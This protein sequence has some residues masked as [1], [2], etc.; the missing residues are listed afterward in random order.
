MLEAVRFLRQC[1]TRRLPFAV[2]TGGERDELADIIQRFLDELPGDV[3]TARLLAPTDSPHAF[4]ESALIQF[5]LEPFDSTADDL[6][7]LLMLVLGQRARE[8]GG[9]IL[10]IEDAQDFGPKVFGLLRD[11]G[12]NLP[13]EGAAPMILLAGSP[14]LHRVLDSRGMA[15]IADLTRCR[16]D[17]GHQQ[18]QSESRSPEIAA[19]EALPTLVLMLESKVLDRFPL[20]RSRTLI[21][22]SIYSDITIASRYV[23]RHH[24]L[25]I[26]ASKGFWLI[27]LKSTNGTLVNS[28]AI[29]QRY[30][31]HGDIISIGNHRLRYEDAAA[32]RAR[33]SGPEPGGH[34]TIVME[35]LRGVWPSGSG[36]G[37]TI[38]PPP[39]I[40][41]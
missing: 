23:S 13:R 15:G 9:V 24:A 12:R 27:D 33:D 34:E 10:L 19:P 2:L 38:R 5:G 26:P 40:G 32:R 6:Q 35:S 21:G 20:P 31:E 14:A 11:I 17:L 25:L 37:G 18:G 16:F 8:P 29:R 30:L 1:A 39:P 4:L 41:T 36:S 7:R 28:R 3:H 22:R